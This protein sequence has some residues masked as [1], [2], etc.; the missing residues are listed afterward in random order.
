MSGVED[1]L[2][3]GFISW[4][5]DASFDKSAEV[6]RRRN[7]RQSSRKDHLGDPARGM[8]LAVEQGGLGWIHKSVPEISFADPLRDRVGCRQEHFIG[9][10]RSNGCIDGETDCWKNASV[11]TLSRLKGCP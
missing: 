11:V 6:I 3:S 8:N 4:I 7:S 1:G 9:H 10:T 2:D 5:I